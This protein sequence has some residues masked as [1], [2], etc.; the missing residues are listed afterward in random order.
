MPNTTLPDALR[1]RLLIYAAAALLLMAAWVA[2]TVSLPL[3]ENWK[4]LEKTNL[5]YKAQFKA[6]V[7]GEWLSRHRHL[8]RQFAART[9]CGR[10]RKP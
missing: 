1:R 3:L 10:N 4:D 7:V 6:Q 5:L 8:A 2:G 9:E